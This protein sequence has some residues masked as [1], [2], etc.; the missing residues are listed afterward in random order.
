MG[1][2]AYPQGCFRQRRCDGGMADEFHY[3]CNQGAFTLT[4]VT[5]KEAFKRYIEERY[6]DQCRWYSHKASINKRNYYLFQ[7]LII[8]FSAITT[9][10]IALGIY[11]PELRW[12]RLLA[13]A[14]TTGV[15]VFVSLQKVFRFQ[16]NW[17]E[18]RDTAESLKKEWYLY[19]AGLDEYAKAESADK[20]FVARVEGL[21]SRQNTA[22]N[23][24]SHNE[25]SARSAS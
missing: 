16:E 21:I 24:R 10:T 13:L 2:A 15:T 4:M 11:F 12:L 25:G 19:Q 22:W 23:T 8:V 6:D 1:S 14:M 9:L 20:S 3:F 17:I 5:D 18:Y 7:T